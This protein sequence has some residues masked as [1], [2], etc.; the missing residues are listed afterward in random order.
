MDSA[1]VDGVLTL[2]FLS[3]TEGRKPYL[4][5]LPN[6]VQ[7]TKPQ[8]TTCFPGFIWWAQQDSNLRPA[9]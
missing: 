8:K 9:D 6:K 7:N 2:S 4:F 5:I 1:S 3:L